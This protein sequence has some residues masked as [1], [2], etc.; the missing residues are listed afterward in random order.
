MKG[1]DRDTAATLGGERVAQVPGASGLGL[2]AS[3]KAV[4]MRMG[5]PLRDVATLTRGA[6]C[7]WAARS[8]EPVDEV[9]PETVRPAGEVGRHVGR[10]ASPLPGR[11]G[12]APRAPGAQRRT[13][14]E[15]FVRTRQ[16]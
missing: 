8:V 1:G 3:R 4:A 5:V 13:R 2:P 11:S 6:R 10:G 7:R 15:A 16:P 9:P 12:Q 14:G